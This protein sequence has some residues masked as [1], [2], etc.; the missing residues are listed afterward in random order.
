MALRIWADEAAPVPRP[1]YGEVTCDVCG[2]T[3]SLSELREHLWDAARRIGFTMTA[4]RQTCRECSEA[5]VRPAPAW[6]LELL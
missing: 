2:R 4:D 5:K 1:I 6:Q 3:W